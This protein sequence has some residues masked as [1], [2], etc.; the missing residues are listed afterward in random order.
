M[1]ST[2]SALQISFYCISF[3]SVCVNY[4][5]NMPFGISGKISSATMERFQKKQNILLA[6]ER[7]YAKIC[8]A[9]GRV[10]D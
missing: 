4:V 10:H 7:M 2:L 6:Y 5:K 1:E 3:F 9:N 8:I